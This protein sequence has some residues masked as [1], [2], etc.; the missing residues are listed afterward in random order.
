M[1]LETLCGESLEND[2][3]T[4]KGIWIIGPFPYLNN[5]LKKIIDINLRKFRLGLIKLTKLFKIVLINQI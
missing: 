3:S 4:R 1:E 5:F 2:D